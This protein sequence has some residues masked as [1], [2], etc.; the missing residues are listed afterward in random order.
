MN[1]L[2]TI[3][4]I[5]IRRELSSVCKK[6]ILIARKPSGVKGYD[7]YDT[8]HPEYQR[9]AKTRDH[10]MQQMRKEWNK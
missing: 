3:P 5:A 2:D 7:Q 8:D 4:M 6:M 9:L 1:K 10:L